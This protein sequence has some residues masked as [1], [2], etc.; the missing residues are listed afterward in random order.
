MDAMVTPPIK[1]TNQSIS[2]QKTLSVAL[3]LDL[4]TLLQAVN[5]PPE[6]KY[7]QD[8]RP[9]AD[10]TERIIH[11]PHHL[12]RLAQRRINRRIFRSIISWPV[13]LYGSI[14]NHRD[15]LGQEISRDYIACAAQH[16]GA[17]SL[18]KMDVKDFFS[19]V[20]E[21]VVYEIFNNFLSFPPD[22]AKLLTE[23]CTFDG[24]LVQGAL[25]SPYLANL[26]LFDL[27]TNVVRRLNQKGLVYTRY[28]DDITVSTKLANYD[29]SFA[30]RII[31]NMLTDKGLPVNS[32]K[33]KI[34]YSS[35]TPLTVHGLR[36]C[37]KEPRLPADEV[38]KIRAAVK[39]IEKISAEKNYRNT[40]A[41]RH[42]FNRCMG[43]V[44]K[45]G[46]VGHKQHKPL[47]G[48]MV[49]VYPLPSKK[50]IERVKLIVLRLERDHPEKRDTYWYS[51]RFYLAHERLNI[52]K[53]SYPSVA[54]QLRIKLKRLG[55]TYA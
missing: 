10:G 24:H 37:F 16:C 25:S 30:K 50:D 21:S 23:L 18:L 27:E 9:K 54:K 12:V 39:N 2:T 53:R 44:N 5:L 38:R 7:V 26:A 28:V 1:T 17:K 13:Y 40:H 19:N 29:F 34:L 42:D 46:R 43:R 14:P 11:K 32:S 49:C 45:L 51:R 41:Y 35:T 8:K 31:E 36:V 47:V 6:M 22:V 4:P 20:H 33:T 48:R 55:T 52:L 3:S 15:E